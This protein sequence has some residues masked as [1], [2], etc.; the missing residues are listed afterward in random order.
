MIRRKI[1]LGLSTAIFV[2]P[3]GAVA[4]TQT[5]ASL[6]NA[7]QLQ[8]NIVLAQNMKRSGGE[9]EGEG[10][11]TGRAKSGGEGEGRSKSRP[12]KSGGEGEGE[13]GHAKHGGEGEGGEGEGGE[14]E[15]KNAAKLEPSLRFYRDL[16][17]LRGHI[18][19]GA[20]LVEQGKWKEAAPHFDHPEKE[21]Y[22]QLRPHLAT[23]DIQPFSTALQALSKAV[24]AKN[25]D[26]YAKAKA[27]VEERLAAADKKLQAK[28]SDW[29]H[30]VVETVV[31]TLRSAAEEYEEGVK[32]GKVRNVIEYQDARGFVL[33]AEKLFGTIADDAAKKN[34]AAVDAVR[35]ALTD[36][37]TALPGPLPPKSQLKEVSFFLGDISKIELQLSNFK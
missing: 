30:F 13:R 16:Q 15:G 29:P 8:P 18:A 35:A 2:S 26:A 19:I 4:D 21:I 12:A 22:G 23:Y 10:R 1:W 27:D 17:R 7:K 3:Q 37:K 9:G 34:Q 32:G 28:E 31:E 20:E 6:H 14:G 36:I 33:Q 5:A 25:K 11:R 24:K